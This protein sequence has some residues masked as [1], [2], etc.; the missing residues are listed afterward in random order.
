MFKIFKGKDKPVEIQFDIEEWREKRKKEIQEGL[1][2][3]LLREE[4]KEL[5]LRKQHGD[6]KYEN[7]LAQIGTYIPDTTD[8]V[9]NYCHIRTIFGLRVDFDYKD[10]GPIVDFLLLYTKGDTE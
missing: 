1:E 2:E 9:R 7:T 6:E 10:Y 5:V 4:I 8:S 3:S